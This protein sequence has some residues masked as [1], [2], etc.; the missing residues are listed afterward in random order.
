M[1]SC[2][3][4][5]DK[6]VRAF[7][8]VQVVFLVLFVGF[9]LSATFLMEAGGSSGQDLRT[10]DLSQEEACRGRSYSLVPLAFIAGGLVHSA[11][12][13]IVVPLAL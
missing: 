5:S 10:V 12:F 8:A 6:V 3:L 11:G 4:S 13:K 1:Q 2:F 9:A 7:V